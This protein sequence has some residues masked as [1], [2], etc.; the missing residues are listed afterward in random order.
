MHDTPPPTKFGDG[1]FNTQLKEN[2]AITP[3]GVGRFDHRFVPTGAVAPYLAHIKV[4]RGNGDNLY[5]DPSAENSVIKI[6][7]MND[8]GTPGAGDLV[9]SGGAVDFL[10]NCDS[11]MNG[12]TA[13]N[14]KRKRYDHPGKGKDFH[15]S[16]IT[17]EKPAGTLKFDVIA[18]GADEE[19]Q[20]ML[21]HIGDP[22]HVEEVKEV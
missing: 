5:F 4:Q 11:R 18:A 16:R 21:W 2:L 1:S 10:I 8:D 9:I 3:A 22:P 17:I 7:L 13:G 14:K 6:G 20:V 19:Y 15:I 12:P